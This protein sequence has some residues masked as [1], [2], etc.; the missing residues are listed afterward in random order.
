MGLYD[1]DYAYERQPGIHLRSPQTVVGSI[2]LINIGVY[3]LQLLIEPFTAWF[4]AVPNWFQRP[5][6]IYRL[7]TYGFLHDYRG[8]G[9]NFNVAFHLIGNMFLFWLLGRDLEQLY[10]KR[11]FL[12]FYLWAIFFAGLFWSLSEA[13]LGHD[14]PMYGA[15]GGVTAIFVLYAFHFPHREMLLFFVLPV[16]MWLLALFLVG[17]DIYGSIY[18][19]SNIAFTA[20]LAGAVAGLYFYK[21]GFSPFAWIADRLS[22]VKLKR[23][24]KLRVHRPDLD[25]DL[26]E[27]TRQEE[28]LRKINEHGIDSLTDSERRY[29]EQASERYRRKRS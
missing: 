2:V 18:R 17:H 19:T 1:R 23:K 9:E 10:G 8:F 29:L 25:E 20:H 16:P 14:V 7:L 28:I 4:Y 15:S 22:G 3:V 21:F 24:P 13:S 11:A 27:D 5:W 26:E 6:E 12:L